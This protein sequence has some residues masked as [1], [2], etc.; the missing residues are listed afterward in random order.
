MKKTLKKTLAI[1]LTLIALFALSLTAFAAD[2]S[3]EDAKAIAL[4]DAG[5]TSAD[6]IYIAAEY[7][8]DDGWKKWNVDF[9]VQDENGYYVDYD[10]EISASDGR[11]LE[12]DWDYED[13]YIPGGSPIVSIEDRI[14][15]F[16]QKLIAWIV[17]LF[18]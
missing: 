14:E 6:A 3:A 15:A 11:I 7:E 1:A 18:S 12:R 10:Y 5:F 4:K 16:F 2:I 13:D 17:S 8:L 9:L